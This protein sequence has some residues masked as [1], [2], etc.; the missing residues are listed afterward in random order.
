MTVQKMNKIVIS[1]IDDT[2]IGQTRQAQ[3]LGIYPTLGS[4]QI[5]PT[6]L[7]PHHCPV[8]DTYI[9][10]V[11][12]DSIITLNIDNDISEVPEEYREDIVTL[13]SEKEDKDA[14]PPHQEW[15]YKIK[16]KP[17]IKPIKQPIYPLSPEKL[18]VLRTYL[19]KNRRKG[20]I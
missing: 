4:P 2:V 5:D 9:T 15:D 14:L 20:F 10:W 3:L 6:F 16:L 11:R 13:F 1:R 18:K 19:N 7:H 17:G 12:N 8:T